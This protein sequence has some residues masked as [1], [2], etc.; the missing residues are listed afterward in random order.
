M[1]KKDDKKSSNVEYGDTDTLKDNKN[2]INTKTNT[3]IITEKSKLNKNSIEY[4]INN[5]P[6][7]KEL[8]NCIYRDTQKTVYYYSK[9]DILVLLLFLFY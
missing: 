3:D 8:F 2:S 1:I 9:I 7:G 6:R 5:N 4:F